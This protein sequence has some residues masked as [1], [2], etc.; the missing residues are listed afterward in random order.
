MT[1][2]PRWPQGDKKGPSHFELE[3]QGWHRGDPTTKVC[4]NCSQTYEW[5]GKT[6]H[7]E[8][9]LFNFH[10]TQMHSETCT[11]LADLVQR[12]RES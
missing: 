9:K 4:R 12:R 1:D 7:V 6:D 5:W 2:A 10:T 3:K 11:A 8:W